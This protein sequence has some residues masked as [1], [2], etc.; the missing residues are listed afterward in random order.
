[1]FIGA[2]I[3]NNL[4]YR[5]KSAVESFGSNIFHIII[6]Y[7]FEEE[8]IYNVTSLEEWC[9]QL[10]NRSCT[11]FPFRFSTIEGV[12]QFPGKSGSVIYR[13]LQRKFFS[14]YMGLKPADIENADKS[15]KC[16]V[17]FDDMLGTSDQFTSFVN[18][19]L[20]SRPDIKFVYI[21]LVAH[22]DGLDAMVRNFPDIIINPVEILNHE[23]SFFS[24]ENL[25]FKGRVTPD[26]AIN[27]YNDLCKR[28][29]IKAKKVHGHGDMALTYSFSDST[30]NN[31]IP[32]LWYDSP[33]WS[34]L[35]TR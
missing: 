2:A 17:F 11:N 28:K 34:A 4:I 18:Q 24:S 14:R 29:N 15:I 10:K 8:R 19:Y 6:P 22:Q 32:L 5:S 20:K 25:L 9:V 16:V 27:L 3:L 7:V 21:P 12:D 30:P 33:E 31:N 13:I 1:M 26:E 35:L 23:N